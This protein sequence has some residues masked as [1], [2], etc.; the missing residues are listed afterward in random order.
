MEKKITTSVL[1]GIVLSL[2]L[3]VESVIVYFTGL[4]MQSW[5]KYIGLAIFAVGVFWAINNH[6]KEKQHD[7]SYGELFSF[8]FKVSAVV[9]C[10]I[11]LYTVLSEAL[12][13]EMKT[14][15]MEIA[16]QQALN[17]PGADPDLVDKGLAVYSDHYTLYNVIIVIFAFVFLGLVFSLIAA[18]I[19]KK[20]P[21]AGLENQFK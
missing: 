13:P 2:V 21:N 10:F 5:A 16:R 17:Q 1:A 4:Y 9:T 3:I 8:G 12:F 11:V 6:A 7:V 15:M 19:P 14:K 20:N 18:A